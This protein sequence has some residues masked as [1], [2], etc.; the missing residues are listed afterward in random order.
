MK[1]WNTGMINWDRFSD[2]INMGGK[3]VKKEEALDK[4]GKKLGGLPLTLDKSN[5]LIVESK[6]CLVSPI[7]KLAGLNLGCACR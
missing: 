4:L 5:Q 7:K 1:G 2:F 3:P 6:K